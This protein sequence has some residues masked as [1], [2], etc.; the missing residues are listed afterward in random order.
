MRAA[1]RSF[2]VH[3]ETW[4][5]YLVSRS[6][7]AYVR[8]KILAKGQIA[9]SIRIRNNYAGS[10]SS[11][12]CSLVLFSFLSASPNIRFLCTCVFEG[13]MVDLQLFTREQIETLI[14]QGQIIIV[15]KDEVLRLDNWSKYHPGGI[16]PIQHMVGKDATDPISVCV[17][18][19]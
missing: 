16:L 2:F 11:K 19:D 6:C 3:S 14:D 13:N 12:R 7:C 9:R 5:R 18:M 10:S 8:T 17:R 15:F 4:S 1:H